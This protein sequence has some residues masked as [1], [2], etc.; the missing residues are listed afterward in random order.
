MWYFLHKI[1]NKLTENETNTNFIS[2]ELS[3]QRNRKALNTLRFLLVIFVGTV[4]P[5]YIF[6]FV[7]FVMLGIEDIGSRLWF[8]YGDIIIDL[9]EVL[10]YTNNVVNVFVYIKMFPGFRRFLLKIFTFGRCDKT[11]SRRQ[12]SNSNGDIP[13]LRA[14]LQ[15]SFN[16]TQPHQ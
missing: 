10:F 7:S 5:G 1:E 12:L 4:A 15:S 3:R 14:A 9:S 2:S 13:S 6:H 16:R 11:K 8:L